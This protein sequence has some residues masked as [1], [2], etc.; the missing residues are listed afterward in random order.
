M[1]AILKFIA[2]SLMLN[3]C[4]LYCEDQQPTSSPLVQQQAEH[5]TT[6]TL[7]RLVTLINRTNEQLTLECQ[8][9]DEEEIC[10]RRKQEILLPNFQS[11]IALIKNAAGESQINITAPRRAMFRF[12]DEHASISI[13]TGEH[14]FLL[15]NNN[16]TQEPT[17]R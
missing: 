11:L 15:E 3:P 2:L 7:Y 17:E 1:H 9:F 8:C 4:C 10:F 6:Q 13:K 14:G 12:H 5:H 16:E